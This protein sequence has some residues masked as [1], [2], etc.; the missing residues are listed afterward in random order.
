MQMN[1]S[2]QFI[3]TDR[4]IWGAARVLPGSGGSIDGPLN[5]SQTGP[6]GAVLSMA[7]LVAVQIASEF[8]LVRL[9]SPLAADLGISAGRAAQAISISGRYAVITRLGI[10]WASGKID[11]KPQQSGFTG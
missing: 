2:G 8:M 3:V 11:R 10:T 9:L 4:A 1:S 7:L 6:R 5:A